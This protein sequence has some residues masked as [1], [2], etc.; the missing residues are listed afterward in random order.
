MQFFPRPARRFGLFLSLL[1]AGA[2]P[3]LARE[4]NP[5]RAPAVQNWLYV[6]SDVPQDKEWIFGVLPNGLRYAVRKNG[7]PPQQVSIRILADAGSLYETEA[8]RGFAHLIEHLTFR[9]SKYLKSGEAI[10]TWQRL[11]ATF[12]SDTNAETSGTQTVY[13]LDLPDA[14]PSKLDETFMLLSGMIT[15]PVFTPQGVKTEVPIVLAEM[16]ERTGPQ[17]RV[18]DGTR[19]V[20]FKGQLVASRSPIG[21]VE[22]LNAATPETVKAFHDKWYRP[23]NTV[24]VV[25]GDADPQALIA[26]IKEW[27]GGW[28]AQGPKPAQPDFGTPAAPPGADPKNP[29]DGTR[30]LVEPGLPRVY[31]YA[32][33]RPW[34]KH[35]DTIVY[36]QGMMIDRLAL[37]LINRR[38]ETRARAGGSYLAASVE[39]QNYSRSA[40]TTVVSITPLGDDWKAAVHDVRAVIADALATPPSAEDIAREIAEFEVAF[41]VP[42]ETQE[43]QAG[44]KLA[45]DITEAVDIRETV[46]NPDT[47]Y[48]IFQRS[49]PLFKPAAVLAHTRAMFT[50]TVIRG[51]LVTPKA[52]DGTAE[53]VRAAL[54][55]PVD[56]AA[57]IR[58]ASGTL[59]FADL[60]ALGTPGTVADA[61]QTGLLGSESVTLSNG[62]K[63]LLWT[64]DAEPG[65]IIVRVRFGGGYAAIAPKDALY[66]SL[67]ENA[68]MDSGFGKLDRNDL[69]RLATGR[70]LS[71]DFKIDD[72]AFEMSA[73]TRPADLADQ[74]YLMAGKLAAPRWDANPVLRARAAMAMQYESTN[75]SPQAVLQRD[76]QWLLKNRDPRYA[77]PDPAALASV[78][79]EDFRRVW[80]PLL[81]QGP[82]E[83]DLFGDFKREAA[84][85]ALQNT[86]GALTQRTPADTSGLAPTV[87]AHNEEPLVLTHRG[88]PGTAAAMVCANRVSSNCSRKSSTI[89]CSTKCA[90]RSARAMRRRFRPSGRWT[91]RR[92]AISPPRC[93]CGR[94]TCPRS[95]PRPTR[96][97]TTLPP[98]RRRLTRSAV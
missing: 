52:T 24:I 45:D 56:A 58:L 4:A 80:E 83:I 65:R 47:V 29:V 17:T 34:K 96:S 26:R 51:V 75:A 61:Q 85:A 82:I 38:L 92:G 48:G 31:N 37:A 89:A 88:D 19:E 55:A 68:L 59:K 91:C 67:G 15:A 22:T 40:D 98:R 33:V 46:A 93:N 21:T 10:P 77:Q 62:V 7:V 3:V 14:T 84:I 8:Q 71:L 12:G 28:T 81:S 70:K 87:P 63:A 27:F 54:L 86:F 1:L 5:A 42:V 35:N 95:L 43:T 13:K 32:I 2:S 6:G 25:A 50:G 41:K 30:V 97:P 64:N 73:D 76:A 72:T 60:P 20:F 11:G 9:D 78:T 79:P 57:G 69:D 18:L 44:S 94:K 23:D 53:D 16:R 90:R 49:V 36:N 74:L 39:Q 66:A